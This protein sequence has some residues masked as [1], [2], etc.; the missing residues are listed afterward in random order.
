MKKISNAGMLG[1]LAVLASFSVG[2]SVFAYTTIGTQLDFGETNS[3]VSSLQTFFADN[4]SIYPEGLVTGYFGSLTR[5]AV[6]RFQTEYSIVS[7][8]SAAT[9][10]FGRVGPTTRDRINSLISNGGWTTSTS[11][12]SGP[13]LYSV[14]KTENNNS[15]TFTW[16]TNES[17]VSKVFYNT[18]PITMNEGDI[19]SVGFG[20][21]NGFTAMGD[22]LARTAHQITVTGLQP[23]TIY[24]YVIVSTDLKGNV[25]VAYPNNTL[26]TTN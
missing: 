3:D 1:V 9:T 21:T 5:S 16:N 11:D 8:G 26:R 4:A 14:A 19:N 2:T 25:S 23:N 17:A 24:Y 18:S 10:G 15:A 7:S 13:A 22:G 6:Q 12:M 20:A